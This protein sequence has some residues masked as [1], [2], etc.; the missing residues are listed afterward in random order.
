MKALTLLFAL[1]FSVAVR[2][3]Q[4]P[5]GKTYGTKPNNA[6][7]MDASKV[8]AFMGNK[9]RVSTT[10]RGKVV[11]VTNTKGGWFELEGTDGKIIAAHFKTADVTIP[12]SLAGHYVIAE[13]VV[14][15]QF[16]A[17]DKQ[18]LAGDTKTQQKSNTG[19]LSFEVTGLEVDK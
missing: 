5:H 3:Q 11:K 2:A 16:V 7:M 18:H 9:V 19:S 4:M 13:G 10:L 1:L 14:A 6:G 12:A 15:K 17:D 8:S